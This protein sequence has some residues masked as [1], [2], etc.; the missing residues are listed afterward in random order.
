MNGQYACFR[1]GETG[2]IKSECPNRTPAAKT[3]PVAPAPPA[4]VITQCLK[5]GAWGEHALNCGKPPASPQRIAE[6][7][8]A[9]GLDRSEEKT[10]PFRQWANIGPR[11]DEQLRRIAREQVAE[12][13]ANQERSA[14]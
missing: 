9:A 3:P 11:R 7:I 6:I 4:P 1:C 2:H 10:S 12:A 5:C 8:F 13:R 14:A